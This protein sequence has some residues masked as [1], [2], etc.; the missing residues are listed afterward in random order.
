M[1]MYA[2]AHSCCLWYLTNN[3]NPPRISMSFSALLRS[4]HLKTST[5]RTYE[6]PTEPSELAFPDNI[7]ESYLANMI[8]AYGRYWPRRRCQL[9]KPYLESSWPIVVSR[10]PPFWPREWYKFVPQESVT[11]QFIQN[12]WKGIVGI[13]LGDHS[14]QKHV[15]EST[16]Q[17]NVLQW[18]LSTLQRS[19]QFVGEKI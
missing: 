15:T 16:P 9:F 10:G 17:Q 7:F 12:R 3:V 6:T 4:P 19:K 13:F 8:T 2:T 5:S 18:T 11:V 14:D 1:F